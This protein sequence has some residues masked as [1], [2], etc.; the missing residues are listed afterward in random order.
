MSKVKYLKSEYDEDE[1]TRGGPWSR[2]LIN[3]WKR[4]LRVMRGVIRKE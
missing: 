1:A 3:I 2:Y 4:G